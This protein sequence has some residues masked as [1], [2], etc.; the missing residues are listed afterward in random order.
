ML[1]VMKTLRKR[2]FALPALADDLQ[3]RSFYV[4]HGF[5]ASDATEIMGNWMELELEDDESEASDA[6]QIHAWSILAH[7]GGKEGREFLIDELCVSCDI[8]NDFFTNYFSE[9]IL[10]AGPEAVPELIARFENKQAGESILIEFASALADFARHGIEKETVLK[11]LVAALQDDPRHRSLKGMIISDLVEISADT[12]LEE[13]RR[14]FDENLVDVT[15]GG[16]FEDVEVALGL[17]SE[18]S[19]VAP[20]WGD[21]EAELAKQSQLERIGPRPEEGDHA[22]IIRYFLDLHGGQRSLK[23]LAEFDGFLLGSILAPLPL[24]PNQILRSIWDSEEHLYEPTWDSTEDLQLFVEAVMNYYNGITQHL[25]EGNYFPPF[26]PRSKL[27]VPTVEESEWARG[28]LGSVYNWEETE[29]EPSELHETLTAAALH[30][31]RPTQDA[32]DAEV[33]QV[34]HVVRAAYLLR[35][36][37]TSENRFSHFPNGIDGT[38][39]RESPK[40]GRNDPCACGSGLK[41]KRCCMN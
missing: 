1:L 15:I 25:D 23:S 34:E 26:K 4:D 11:A 3:P 14:A 32:S 29:L 35:E 27:R 20:H 19:S 8:G 37:L 24:V 33:I 17:R 2:L 28:I 12:Y 36:M 13:I 9:L 41:Y 39:K 22:G 10:A 38:E 21:R 40:I 31:I 6:A 7:L 30:L 5:T 16:D 18:R